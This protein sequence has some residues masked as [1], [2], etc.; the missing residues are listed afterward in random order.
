M[1]YARAPRAGRRAEPPRVKCGVGGLDLHAL[2]P[3]TASSSLSV[4]AALVLSVRHQIVE[5]GLPGRDPPHSVYLSLGLGGAGS[6]SAA[7]G[8]GE[9]V[10]CPVYLNRV[11]RNGVV[12]VAILGLKFCKA[13]LLRFSLAP[14]QATWRSEPSK[15]DEGRITAEVG[16]KLS[17]AVQRGSA[18]ASSFPCHYVHMGSST[19]GG[20]ARVSFRPSR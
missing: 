9:L 10:T 8:R 11:Y 14:C 6:I 4:W 20:G 1:H 3:P 12:S 5:V 15:Q 17:P 13:P 16:Q 7:P 2:R 19:A 18:S